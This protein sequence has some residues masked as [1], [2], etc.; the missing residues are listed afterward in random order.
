MCVGPGGSE[1]WPLWVTAGG[2]ARRW[3]Q[4]VECP[5]LPRVCAVAKPGAAYEVV[6]FVRLGYTK[7]AAGAG[8]DEHEATASSG[9]MTCSGGSQGRRPGEGPLNRR[10]TDR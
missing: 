5:P 4:S 10:Q 1:W 9:R 2:G 6:Y 7:L 3:R 8:G